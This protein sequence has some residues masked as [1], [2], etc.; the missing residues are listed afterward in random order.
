LVGQLAG[1][2]IGV[3]FFTLGKL[4]ALASIP[5]ALAAFGW[6]FIPLFAKRFRLTNRRVILQKGLVPHDG[7]A[8]DLDEFD[9]IRID[10]LP[11]Q[12]W[13][14]CGDLVFLQ[15]DREMLRLSGVPRPAVFRQA[16]L[17]AQASMISVREVIEAQAAAS[18]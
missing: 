1:S 6:Q 13:L 10:V 15:G 9:A 18:C 17:K 5:F 12:E 8:V 11:G 4:F 3:G 2:R 14:R 16:C 7:P